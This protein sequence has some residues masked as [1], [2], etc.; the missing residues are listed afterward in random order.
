VGDID[1]GLVALL[2]A[3]IVPSI[4]V[5]EVSHGVAAN[6]LG[7]DTAK[8]AGRLTLNPVRHV[9][10][11]GTLILPA[12]MALSGIGAFGYAK[13]VPVDVARL[14]QPRRDA[15][16]VSLAGPASNIVLAIAA[17]LLLR[18]VFAGDFVAASDL[19]DLALLPRAVFLFGFLNL[20]LATFNLLP[21]PPLDGSAI[22]ERF[23]PD[24]WWPTWLKFRQWGFGILL[25]LLLVTP[26]AFDRIFEPVLDAWAKVLP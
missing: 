10:P 5:H 16:L 22:V 4:V 15:L 3:V 1:W 2:L 13:P 11:F 6:L 25:V 7:D 18:D 26:G 24:R 19:E 17:T 14:R 20:L 12:M 9:D 8:R 21:I 23:L